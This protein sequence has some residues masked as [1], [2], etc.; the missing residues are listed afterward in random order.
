VPS[1]PPP[2]GAPRI[3]LDAVRQ[4]ARELAR[5]GS[6]PRTL[7]PFNVKPKEETRTKEQQAFDKALKRPDCRDAYAGMGLAAV[8]PLLWDSVSEKGCKW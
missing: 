3:D 2:G 6:G 5:E 4:R 8:V 7:L 1:L